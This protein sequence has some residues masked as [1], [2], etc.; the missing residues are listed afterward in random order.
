M[1]YAKLLFVAIVVMALT[2]FSWRCSSA[3]EKAETAQGGNAMLPTL[4]LDSLKKEY[5]QKMKIPG[6]RLPLNQ[7]IE[8]GRLY[9]VDEGP[10]DTSF[11]VFRE[12]LLALVQKK[13]ILQLMRVIDPQIKCSFGEDNGIAA[14]VKQWGLD[15]PAKTEA[16]AIWFHLSRLLRSGGTFDAQKQNFTAPYWYSSFPEE[17]DGLTHG[18]IIGSGVRVRATPELT[19]E[20]VQTISYNIVEVLEV[21]EKKDTLGPAAF[22]WYKVKLGDNKQ[23]YVFGQFIGLPSGYRAGFTRLPNHEWRLVMLV[24]GD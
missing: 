8:A 2:V 14:F 18:A 3:N 10:L 16:S 11:F 24:E 20:I 21:S 13:D 17:V 6:E 23:G 15:T 9:P 5:E 1:N 19:G 22:P 4:S 7:I 12:W